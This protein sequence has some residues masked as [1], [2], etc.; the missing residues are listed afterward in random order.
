MDDVWI[1]GLPADQ[2]ASLQD[3]TTESGAMLYGKQT[4]MTRN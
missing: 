2:Y 3:K 4:N 1:G